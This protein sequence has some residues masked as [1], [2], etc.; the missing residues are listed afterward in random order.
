MKRKILKIVSFLCL[1][2]SILFILFALF[3]MREQ[4]EEKEKND[5]IIEEAAPKKAIP[6][7]PLDRVIDW[8][9]LKSVNPDIIAWLYIPG[10]AI[11]YPVCHSEGDYYLRRNIYRQYS[12][13]GSL[14][15][16]ETMEY[17]HIVIFGHNMNSDRMFG[18]LQ[19]S[20][21]QTA[22]IYTPDGAGRYKKISDLICTKQ[23]SIFQRGFSF[24]KQYKEWLEKQ[25]IEI[26]EKEQ[27]VSLAVCA[28][29]NRSK[30]YVAN[31]VC[32]ERRMANAASDQNT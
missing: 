31:I 3:E 26:E 10:T 8:A 21:F 13:P 1:I 4:E 11:D 18:R 30:R 5:E 24:G 32:E 23:D 25:G 14:F 6:E 22:Y 2:L 20:G 28:D 7:D 29:G 19:E 15:T 17:P 16:N 12:S 9:Y 27:V